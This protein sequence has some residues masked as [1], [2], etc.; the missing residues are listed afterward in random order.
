MLARTVQN[1]VQ[2]LSVL[3]WDI[4]DRSRRIREHTDATHVVAAL[5]GQT[6]PKRAPNI[7]QPLHGPSWPGAE[8]ARDVTVRVGQQRPRLR[9]LEVPRSKRKRGRQGAFHV[10]KLLC[11]FLRSLHEG[12]DHRLVH[13]RERVQGLGG[14]GGQDVRRL[15]GALPHEQIANLLLDH[16][17]RLPLLW[18]VESDAN[19]LPARAPC[20]AASMHVGLDVGI[21]A[22]FDGRLDHD[23]QIDNHVQATGSDVR[24]HQHPE[25]PFAESRQRCLTLGLRDVAMER[26]ALIGDAFVHDELVAVLLPL[27]EHNRPA[28]LPRVKGDDVPDGLRAGLPVARDRNVGHVGGRLDGAVADEVDA[29]AIL[30]Q[31][32]LLHFTDPGRERRAEQEGLP[33]PVAAVAFFR[34][35]HGGKN[36][37]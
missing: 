32:L 19:P 33:R 5:L 37:L 35:A 4:K 23:H 14:R 21:A 6:P 2:H 10:P 9:H 26:L 15:R 16:L 34:A 20:P 27:A 25:P 28:L 3:A 1:L 29:E 17:Q 11:R 8:L 30:P 36:L 22:F 18:G 12:R 24:G 7:S 13:R 31:E